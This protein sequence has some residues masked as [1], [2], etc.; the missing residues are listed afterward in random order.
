MN[1]I[2]AIA[3]KELAG[4]F[5]SPM[6]YLVLIITA[7][8]FNIFFFMIIDQ[9]QEANLRDVFLVMEFMFVFLV[10]LLTM[11]VLA[12]ERATG[13]IEFLMTSPT[14]NTAIVMG[15]YLGSLAFFTLIIILTFPYYGIVEYF[16][17]PDRLTIF[18]GYLGIW[19][20]GSLFLAIGILIS[21]CTCSQIVAAISSYAVIF[22]LYFAMSFIQYFEGFAENVIRAV[23][24]M[25]HSESFF[26][27]FIATSDVVYYLSGILFCIILACISIE[28]RFR[29]KYIVKGIGFIF[30]CLLMAGG[31]YFVHKH[32]RKIDF[33]LLKQHTLDAHTKDVTQSLKQD[34]RLT[35]FYVGLPPKYI[36]DLLKAYERFSNGRIVTEI[37]D[38]L[39]QLGYASQFGQV[40]SSN[41]KK[42]FVQSGGKQ[43]EVDFT[44]NP[45]S[46]EE[47]TNAILRVTQKAQQIYFLTGHG[48]FNFSDEGEKGLSILAELLLANNMTPHKLML[49]ITGKIPEDC[50]VLMVAGAQNHFTLEEEKIINEYLNQGGDAVFLVE[51]TLVT[52][53]DKLLTEEEKNKNPSL[54]NI[55]NA[56]GIRIAND[57]VVD[58]VS[59]AGDDV[60]SP[61]TRNYLSHKAIVRDLD[62]TFYVRPRSISIVGNRRKTIK[63]API[64]LTASKEQSWGE[65]NR[66]LQVKFD[67]GVDRAGPVPIAFVMWEPRGELEK[68]TSDTRLAVFTDA[69]FMTN[70]FINHYSNAQMALNVVSW[71]SELD[72]K[73]FVGRQKLEVQPLDLT[74]LQKRNVIIL[75][76]IMPI[77]IAL[78]GLVV[79]IRGRS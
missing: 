6:A 9:N 64:V 1:K 38:P 56:W 20:E 22:M 60:G 41:E 30:L 11:K 3:K 74:S 39:V 18:F 43:K 68:K 16:G 19:L 21:S 61:A 5:K 73:I 58:L 49:G 66:T 78:S 45:L 77:L 65:T 40:I 51:H 10:P 14:S 75:L 53:A 31:N 44:E 36:E 17:A 57:I 76:C 8:V 33:T 63:L 42:V 35:A 25:P 29:H 50:D 28:N 23:S 59:H 27:G 71:V 55:L 13:T 70:V 72:Y 32:D 47:L 37:V 7:S 48:E 69:D 15:K 34:V 62:Y 2:I 26:V 46:E 24:T 12:E 4:Y 67:E 52:T 79:W 54:N